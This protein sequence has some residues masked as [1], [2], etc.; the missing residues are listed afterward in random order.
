MGVN[1]AVAE[2]GPTA[3]TEWLIEALADARKQAQLLADLAYEAWSSEPS[4][5]LHGAYR[6][7]Q[8]QADAVAD[9]LAELLRVL[10]PTLVDGVA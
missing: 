4:P 3:S 1:G 5:V 9:D 2:R 10:R 8:D 6:A 7:A